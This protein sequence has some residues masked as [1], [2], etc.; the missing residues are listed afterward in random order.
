[1]VG[2]MN[3]IYE[4]NHLLVVEKPPNM[5][6]QEDASGDIDLL[7]TLK[8]YIKE[9]YNKPGDVYLGLVHRLDRPVGGVMVFARTSK[10]A[11]RLSAQ[12]SKKQSMKCY[13]AIVCGEVKP[14]DSLFDYLV[15]DEK[16]NTTSVA[17]ETAQGAKP[18]RLRYRRVAKKGGKLFSAGGNLANRKASSDK[19]SACEQK[20][21]DIRRSTLQRY[22]NRGRADSS[23]GVCAYHRAPHTEDADALYFHAA[24][25]GVGRVFR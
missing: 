4:D 8:A 25:Q 2:Q 9:K 10:A 15:R 20:Y 11:A 14:E 3:I 1:M 6:V 18:A 19:G 21:A 22:G 7:R 23:L 24:R 13:A 16:T 12:F 5:P 17:S